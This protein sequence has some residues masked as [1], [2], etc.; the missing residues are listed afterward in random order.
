MTVQIAGAKGAKGKGAGSD[1]DNTLRSRARLRMVELISEGEIVGLVDDDKSIYLDDTPIRNA[2]DSLN[3]DGITWE[4]RTGLADQEAIAGVSQVE[5]PV[6]VEVQVKKSLAAPVRTITE[7]NATAVRVLMRIPSL[8]NSGNDGSLRATSVSYA[9]DVRPYGGAWTEL[10]ANDIIQQKNTSPYEV[11]HRVELPEGG[12]PWDVRVRRITEDSDSTNLQNE[13]W[14]ASYVILVEG[15]FTYPHSAIVYLEVDAERF[16]QQLSTRKYHVKGRKI[17]IPSN[18]DPDTREYTGIWNGTFTTAYCNNPV[19]VYYDLLTNDR[20]GLG[21]FVTPSLIDKATLYLIA[22][23]C[24]ELVPSGLKDE[25]DEDI[26]EPRYTFNGVIANREEAFKVLQTVAAV[27]RGMAYWS[28]GQVF[29]TAD[30]P[31]DSVKIVAPADVKD[32]HFR[33]QGTA[34]RARHSVAIVTWYDPADYYRP[35][36]EVVVDN[37]MLRLHGWRETTIDGIGITSRGQAHRHGR[38][39]LDT[40]KNETEIVN[41]EASWDHG[42]IKPGDLISVA[43]PNKAQAPIGGRI[44]AASGTAITLDRVFEPDIGQT[45]S[46]MVELPSGAVETKTISAFSDEDVTLS[47]AFSTDPQVNAMWAIIGS[48]VAPRQYRVMGV[49]ESGN[50]LFKVSALFH[51]PTKYA[52]V[53]QNTIL[54]PIAYSRPVNTIGQPQNLSVAESLFFQNGQARMRLTLSWSAQDSFKV[55]GYRVT[56]V[57]EEGTTELGLTSAASIDIDELPAG[58]IAFYVTAISHSGLISPPAS[59]NYTVGNWEG[60]DLPYVSHLEVHGTA[61][62]TIFAGQDC[63]ITWRNNFPGSTYEV[64]EEPYGA[65]TGNVNPLFRDNVVR[66]YDQNGNWL[67]TEITTETGY[68]YDYANNVE[69]NSAYDQDAQ[70]TLRFDVTVRDTLG[71]ES[72]IMSMTAQNPVPNLVIPTVYAG[73]QSVFVEYPRPNDLD[74]DG[75]KIWMETESDYDPLVTDPIYEGPNNFLSFPAEDATTYYVR[76]ALYDAFSRTNLEVS[77]PQAVTTVTAAVDIDPPATPSSLSLTG[78]IEIN[79]AGDAQ[80]RLVATMADNASENFAY[81]EIEIRPSG[82]NYV[83]FQTG[84]SRYEWTGLLFNTTYEVRARSVSRNG[85]KSAYT[86]VESILMPAN[87]TAPDVVTSLTAGASL[88]SVYLTFDPPSNKDLAYVE[89]YAHT[90]DNRSLAS[91]IGETHSATLTHKGLT[92]G[93]TWYYWAR[94]VNTSGVAGDWNAV[95]GVVGTPGQVEPGDLAANTVF[96]DNIVAGEITGDHLAIDAELPSSI[97]VGST[98]VTIGAL[99]DPATLVNDGSTLIDPGRILISGATTLASWRNG[100]DATKIEGGSIAANTIQAN[101]LVVGLRGLSI[102]GIQFSYDKDTDTLSW[103]AGTVSYI[104][105]DG[106]IA[107]G[108]VNANSVVWST[109]TIYVTWRRGQIEL[110]TLSSPSTLSTDVTFATYRGG[111]DLVA[112]YGRTIIDGAHI[113]TSSIT[114]TQLSVSE[115]IT[116]SA[117]IGGG[118]ISNA[119]LAGN[120]TFDKLS[121]GTISTSTLIRIGGDNFTLRADERTLEVMDDQTGN[122]ERMDVEGRRRVRLG[123]LGAGAGD[124]GLEVYDTDGTVIFSSS[125]GIEGAW[126]NNLTGAHIE[127]GTIDAD[128]LSVTTLSAIVADFGTVVAGIAR[129]SDSKFVIDLDAGNLVI[130]D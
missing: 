16:G 39:I 120:I 78:T 41:Y 43:D 70:R 46:L 93:D 79:G 32:G 95:S 68:T 110:Q 127:A 94:A 83:A 50:H 48:D 61:S 8:F 13:T 4:E 55:R 101:T 7:T 20:F 30:M 99:T 71:R 36:K 85:Y 108:S 81:N 86:S 89:I 59:L 10:I 11:A 75:A 1:A 19:W 115:L 47:S 26:L 21:E 51:D 12:A 34:L 102:E 2:D 119:H 72:A 53:E 105:D 15:R 130:S 38:W 45:Y 17:Q 97:L 109:G 123:R 54:E 58:D 124:Y 103:S 104:D 44:A 112:N 5:T 29:A 107:T 3:F 56:Y 65:G 14:W 126:V 77:P 96:A 69:D 129:S 118:V 37:E 67:H 64:G 114:A 116:D 117:Q 84:T 92:I 25:S 63:H 27:F 42:L 106:T 125:S 121:G 60:V 111:N 122:Y 128:R 98:G 80:T 35:A 31:G 24:D 62:T 40:E 33:Y 113:L 82:G 18:Y 57:N 22:Q 90:T 49:S 87:T 76:I 23:Y 66:V 6:S 52:R 9:I 74:F 88:Q 91:K 100:S 28:L 73:V